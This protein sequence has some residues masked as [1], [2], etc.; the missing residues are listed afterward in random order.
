MSTATEADFESLTP[1]EELEAAAIKGLDSIGQE[2][3]PVGGREK[4]VT[5]QGQ[6]PDQ[7]V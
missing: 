7:D 4:W 6:P 5:V 3:L 1:E 2:P